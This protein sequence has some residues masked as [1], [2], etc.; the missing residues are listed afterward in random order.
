MTKVLLVDN[1]D[2]F[3]YNLYQYLASL[4]A[5]VDV[6]RNDQID[7]ATIQQEPPTHIV[8]SP[9]PGHPKEKRDIGISGE[10]ITMFMHD[11]PILGVCLGCQT[12]AHVLGGQVVRAP[13]IVHGKTDEITHNGR[14][15]FAGLPPSIDVMRYHSLMVDGQNL[16]DA[17]H[18]TAQTADGII[19]GIAHQVA[20]LV[21][22][23]FHPESIG[24]PN[25]LAM[26]QNF[27]EMG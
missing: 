26:L 22:L 11:L 20:P 25:G 16:P 10:L 2:S 3:V 7:L 19:M 15:L 24:T 13:S 23:Q 27:L 6:Q 4:G 18:T 1:Y 8:I 21:G 12:I 17:L 5:H 9:G 14:G